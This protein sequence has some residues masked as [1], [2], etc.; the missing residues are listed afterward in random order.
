[1][2]VERVAQTENSSELSKT[3][4]EQ[5]DMPKPKNTD[6]D[7]ENLKVNGVLE[8]NTEGFSWIMHFQLSLF[9]CSMQEEESSVFEF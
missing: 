7:T 9:Q 8:S 4:L 3:S 1:M 5:E 2:S 6:S